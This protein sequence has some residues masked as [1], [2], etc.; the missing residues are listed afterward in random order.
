MAMPANVDTGFKIRSLITE[1]V[2]IIVSLGVGFALVTSDSRKPLRLVEHCTQQQCDLLAKCGMA[3]EF[4][5]LL[6]GIL[7][8]S[9]G[10]YVFA[11]GISLFLRRM[12][13]EHEP[14]MR[15]KKD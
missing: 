3:Y 1:A 5:K 14:T 15:R 6:F 13:I 7:L 8:T 9:L 11:S 12:D 2:C 4:A 10:F